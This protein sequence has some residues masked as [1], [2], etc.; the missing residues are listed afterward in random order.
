MEFRNVLVKKE[1]GTGKLI[2]NRPPYNVMD[3]VTSSEINEVLEEFD[4][5]PE[6]K[7]VI[8]TGS[9][10]RYF[11]AG[12]DVGD[13]LGENIPKM[14]EM[15]TKLFNLLRELSKPVIAV[16]NGTALGGGCELV[17]ACDVAIA[18]EKA[19]FGQPEIKLATFPGVAGILYPRMLG[20]KK[21]MEIILT[22]DS[23]DAREAERIGLVNKVV[24]E[25]AL[26]TEAMKFAQRFIEKST[27]ALGLAKKAIYET[28]DVPEFKRAWKVSK[29][30]ALKITLS[31]DGIEGLT[32]FREK[33]KPVW[34]NR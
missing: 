21:A 29:E 12:A 19:K 20:I 30:W 31:E 6:V 22:G 27:Y 33:R 24:P 3:I 10:N 1:E 13:H 15:A 16:V 34:K 14:T 26:E 2:I 25:E 4:K 9:G 32:A 7:V 23:I 18:S 17:A 5:D 28:W 11:S 8:I